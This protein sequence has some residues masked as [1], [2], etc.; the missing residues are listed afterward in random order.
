[1]P[2]FGVT[3]AGFV[4]KPLSAILADMESQVLATI[5]PGFDLSAQTPDGQM[6]GIVAA[7][8]ASGWELLQVAW[9]QFNREDVE[10][11]GLDNLGDLV[12]VPRESETSTQ[13]YATLVFGSGAVAGTY[14]VGTFIANVAGNASF[15]FQ[16]QVAITLAGG[17]QT[18]TGVLM[19]AQTPGATATVNPST[20][21]VITT[22]VTGWLSITN[23]AEQSQ[24]GTNEE[25]DSAY[26]P[27]Q[28]QE[29]A[30]EG[31]CNT[32][33]TA[34]A[35]VK[36]GAAQ[37]PPITI[38]A[39][40]PEN[41][42]ESTLVVQG[43]TLP[44]HTFA[45]V[46]YDN[47]VGWAVAN[48]S[49]IA[50]VIYA[51]QPAGITSIGSTSGNVQDPNLGLQTVSWTLPSGV[52]LYLYIV[53]VPRVGVNLTALASLIQNALVAAA[54]APTPADG[55]PPPAQLIPG[56]P[57]VGSQLEAVV[58]AVP[59]VFDTQG[60]AFSTSVPV[61]LSGTVSVSGGLTSITF[62]T[63]QTIP[64]G[65]VL[66]FASQPGVGYVLATG[67]SG[68]AGVL[69]FA[70]SGTSNAATTTSTIENTAPITVNASQVLTLLQGTIATNVTVLA[71]IYP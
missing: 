44:P 52:P 31:S 62:S 30:A 61:T 71:G 37:T 49:L 45:P 27:R 7:Q 22:P 47:G 56:S 26:G 21:T 36:L 43:I 35:L 69:T 55:L 53:V 20:L 68:T 13:V 65:A 1:M 50:A 24:V 14:P 46:V 63:S 2:S 38:T 48:P 18:L 58:M 29:V 10:G 64:A 11:A 57:C 33:A 15:T 32:A 54:V 41:T 34:A 25:L 39:A 59:G 42:T 8:A 17:A 19:Q 3:A 66:E 28:A 67:V 5:D 70:Y 4:V 16:N 23:P 9:N 51:N 60:L 6:L 12:G 40:V